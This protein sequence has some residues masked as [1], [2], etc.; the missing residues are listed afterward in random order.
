MLYSS[1][2]YHMLSSVIKST[3]AVKLRLL[4][5]LGIH[6]SLY[7]R[8]APPRNNVTTIIH[9]ALNVAAADP[10]CHAEVSS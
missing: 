4:P 10:L 5:Y 3:G 7:R 2:I 9:C 6:R 8:G 1:I